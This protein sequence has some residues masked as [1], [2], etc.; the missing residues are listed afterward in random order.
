MGAA[1]YDPFG[2]EAPSS[3]PVELMHIAA[4]RSLQECLLMV[5]YWRERAELAEDEL[6]LRDHMAKQKRK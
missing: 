5:A 3:A 2:E 1:D 4:L 6:R